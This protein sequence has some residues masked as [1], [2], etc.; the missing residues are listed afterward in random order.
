M[1]KFP[2]LMLEKKNTLQ[3][4]YDKVLNAFSII[5]DQEQLD[6]QKKFYAEPV[7]STDPRLMRDAK[8]IEKLFKPVN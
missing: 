6:Q 7:L 8:K 5:N 3:N 4:D 2:C 1:P